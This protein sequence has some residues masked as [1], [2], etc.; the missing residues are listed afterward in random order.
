V[1]EE[2]V[3]PPSAGEHTAL[4]LR[5]MTAGDELQVRAAQSELSGEGF[6]FLHHLRDGEPWS[7]YLDRLELLSIG[8]G[9]PE[10]WVPSTFLVAEVAGDLVGRTSIRHSLNP[11]LALW[12][13]HIGYAVR[14]AF[15]R[16]GHATTILRQSLEIA[17][18]LGLDKVLLTCDEDNAGSAAVIERCGGVLDNIVPGDNGGPCKRRYWIEHI[19]GIRPTEPVRG[20][21]TSETPV[22]QRVV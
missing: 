16:R 20:P 22:R 5:A 7:T 9:G 17:W 12:G 14:P 13:G 19:P 8:S 4:L 11:W 21:G 18:A 1:E 15:R 3:G 6:T 2:S 10:V